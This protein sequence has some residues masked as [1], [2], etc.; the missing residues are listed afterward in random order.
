[1]TDTLAQGPP[2]HARSGPLSPGEAGL[3]TGAQRWMEAGLTTG[4][5]SK[6][7]SVRQHTPT[8]GE[9]RSYVYSNWETCDEGC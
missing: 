3:A 9:Y 5:M 6:L 7:C 4:D 1:M 8:C 2:G